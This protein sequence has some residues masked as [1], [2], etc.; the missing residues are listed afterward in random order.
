MKS[1]LVVYA[2]ALLA[3]CAGTDF[4]IAEGQPEA[5]TGLDALPSDSGEPESS[6]SDA[7]VDS[8]IET[9]TDAVTLDT[10]QDSVTPDT[11]P[12]TTPDTTSVDAGPDVTETSDSST[13]TGDTASDTSSDTETDTGAP[14]TSPPP[15]VEGTKRCS[16]SQPLV[17]DAT[18]VFVDNGGICNYFCDSYSKQCSCTAVGRFTIITTTH[19]SP[20]PFVDGGVTTGS[21]PGLKDSKTG[22][23]WSFLNYPPP[24]PGYAVGDLSAWC[25]SI[26]P[27]WH[28]PTA[29]ELSALL[30]QT[31]VDTS[32]PGFDGDKTLQT[33]GFLPE[34][35]MTTTPSGLPAGSPQYEMVDFT[36]GTVTPGLKGRIAC[37]K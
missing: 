31:S 29:D 2:L 21:V 9:G 7:E 12:D 8:A 10:G 15:C 6:T 1:Y 34:P 28:L 4:T 17:C 23:T 18:G 27:E 19:S 5:D 25:A 16:G 14:D 30:A 32:C 22:K 11:A 33:F 24:P 20:D 35:W 26:G 3:G 36:D 37:W 13:E